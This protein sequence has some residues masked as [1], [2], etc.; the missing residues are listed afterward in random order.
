MDTAKQVL[1][2]AL[3]THGGIQR[4]K[5]VQHL[6][7][8]WSFHGAMFKLRLREGQLQKLKASIWTQKPYVEIGSYLNK[9]TTST[10]APTHVEI[11]F[12]DG[13]IRSR[14]NIRTTFGGLRTL[15]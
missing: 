4:W 7:T 9:G 12:P 1:E 11:C 3:D 5:T 6:E 15:L 14:E 2:H 10:F 13:T 8:T